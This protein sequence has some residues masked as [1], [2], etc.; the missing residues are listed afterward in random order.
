MTEGDTYF[1]NTLQIDAYNK[2]QV[3]R[4]PSRIIL[5]T[6]RSVQLPPNGSEI[7]IGFEIQRVSLAESM[8]HETPKSVSARE[9]KSRA[10]SLM[11][12]KKKF[13]SIKVGI[14]KMRVN[15]ACT[16]A[17]YIYPP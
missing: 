4:D 11:E 6:I 12:K 13:G 14:D 1:D 9:M 3:K 2:C 10:K 16:H 7:Y 15:D 17:H 8:E 5:M